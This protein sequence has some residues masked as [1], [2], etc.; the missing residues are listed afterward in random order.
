MQTGRMIDLSAEEPAAN[1]SAALE[2]LDRDEKE[3]RAKAHAEKLAPLL[4]RQVHT[5]LHAVKLILDRIAMKG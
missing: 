2:G 1:L 5:N 3:E 4:A